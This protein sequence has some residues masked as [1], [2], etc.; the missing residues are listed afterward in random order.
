[1]SLTTSFLQLSITAQWANTYK[2][3]AACI[4]CGTKPALGAVCIKLLVVLYSIVVDYFFKFQN[5]GS[6]KVLARDKFS[7]SILAYWMA[8]ALHCVWQCFT[9]KPFSLNVYVYTLPAESP[10]TPFSLGERAQVPTAFLLSLFHTG[11]WIFFVRNLN[12]FHFVQSGN[13][14]CLGTFLQQREQIFF[15][16]TTCFSCFRYDLKRK[17]LIKESTK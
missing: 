10:A 7:F 12:C 4:L 11:R 9:N 16:S 15:C 2:I 5:M 13:T 3:T 6:C 17:Y 14:K 8:Y 1:M